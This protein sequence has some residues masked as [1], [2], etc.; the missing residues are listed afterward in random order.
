MKIYLVMKD[1]ETCPIKLC[2]SAWTGLDAHST[3]LSAGIALDLSI[4][5]FHTAKYELVHQ[6]DHNARWKSP[7]K[8]VFMRSETW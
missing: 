1:A 5:R 8:T 3:I 7:R 2:R 6:I 4:K